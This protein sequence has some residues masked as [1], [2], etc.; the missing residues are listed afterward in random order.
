[1]SGTRLERS[2]SAVLAMLVQ[3]GP[4]SRRD[5]AERTGLPKSTVIDLAARLLK[6]G[7]VEEVNGDQRGV[8]GRPATRLRVRAT[9]SSIGTVGIARGGLVAAVIGSDGV[10]RSHS[11]VAVDFAELRGMQPAA[12]LLR[13]AVRDAGLTMK[14]L[15]NVV[16]SLPTPVH[17]GRPVGS[18]RP[19]VDS[20]PDA[21]A[22]R[23][24]LGVDPAAEL[25]AA[26]KRPVTAENDANLGALGE[27]VFGIGRPFSLLIHLRVVGGI[28]GGVVIDKRLVRGTS[29]FAGEFAHLH[30]DD[31]GPRCSCGARG[32]LATQTELHELMRLMRPAFG[33]EPNI[34][35]LSALCARGDEPTLRR[36]RD[37]GQRLGAA[38]GVTC[39]VLNPDVLVVDGALGHAAAPLI[40]GLRQG[41]AG[42]APDDA[43]QSVKV[44]PGALPGVAGIYGALALSMG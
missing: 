33:A 31:S 27:A 13:R 28:G 35:R 3:E 32:C 20:A 19:G 42:N 14:S 40:D 26:L 36:F 1:M 44:L 17:Q 23:A 38:V 12:D 41:M 29:G 15:T 16:L 18:R 30:A 8:P 22:R 37:L 4:L 24:W 10:I 9:T 21:A 6:D 7:F 2:A 5:L 43:V 25:Q 34:D 11:G 39:V